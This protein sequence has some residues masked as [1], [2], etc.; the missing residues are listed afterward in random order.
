M[1]VCASRYIS[2][3]QILHFHILDTV[4][5]TPANSICI[6]H[7]RYFGPETAQVNTVGILLLQCSSRK[8]C[9]GYTYMYM[10]VLARL[11]TYTSLSCITFLFI[12]CC[13]LSLF[14]QQHVD[15]LYLLLFLQH[16]PRLVYTCTYMNTHKLILLSNMLNAT[17]TTE[18][19][20]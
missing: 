12:L 2:A 17:R 16:P 13:L 15:T 5:Y 11:V 10:H 9:V 7:T 8:S 3:N 6:S 20:N 14:C 19:C 18:V 4:V 1:Y